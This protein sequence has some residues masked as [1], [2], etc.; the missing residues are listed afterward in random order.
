[1]L[2]GKQRARLRGQGQSLNAIFY[3][4]KLGI[5]DEIIHQLDN[6]INAR[7]LIKVGVQEMCPYSAREAA[8]IISKELGAEE[9][10]VVGRKFVLYRQSKDPKKRVITLD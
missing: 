10:S 2:T 9:V 4:G 3:I 5:T 7:E 1:M 6:A 8:D